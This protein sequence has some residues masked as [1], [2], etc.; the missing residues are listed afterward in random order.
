MVCLSE[1]HRGLN[2]RHVICAPLLVFSSMSFGAIM[3]ILSGHR[4]SKILPFQLFFFCFLFSQKYF[5]QQV[6]LF[7]HKIMGL[8]AL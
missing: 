3:A 5:K 1:S 6:D 7:Q 8:G 4:K 2:F